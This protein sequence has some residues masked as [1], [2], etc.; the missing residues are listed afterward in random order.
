MD[1]PAYN[2]MVLPL[3]IEQTM[4][5]SLGLWLRAGTDFTPSRSQKGTVLSGLQEHGVAGGLRN[6]KA[7]AT[8]SHRQ[9]EHH[10]LQIFVAQFST[11][12]RLRWVGP[13]WVLDVTCHAKTPDGA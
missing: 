5:K 12:P 3:R 6:D 4:W 1:F 11:V 9:C 13:P 7:A 10:R 8:W 2:L